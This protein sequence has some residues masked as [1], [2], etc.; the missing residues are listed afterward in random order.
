MKD[1]TYQDADGQGWT[2]LGACM[3]AAVYEVGRPPRLT[4]EEAEALEAQWQ[5][6][7]TASLFVGR[8]VQVQ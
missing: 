4:S 3:A 1:P 7:G 6:F 5:D 2:G 8:H